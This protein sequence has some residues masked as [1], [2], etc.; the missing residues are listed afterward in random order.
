MYNIYKI[1]NTVDRIEIFLVRDVRMDPSINSIELSIYI[2]N[3]PV[4]SCDVFTFFSFN[5]VVQFCME[6]KTGNWLIG[7]SSRWQTRRC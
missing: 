5:L 6:F 2:F 4:C 3:T 7:V 1:N